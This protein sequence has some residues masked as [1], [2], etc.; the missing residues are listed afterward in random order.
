MKG[1]KKPV[2]W[3][4]GAKGE[5]KGVMLK[6]RTLCNIGKATRAVGEMIRYKIGILGIWSGFGRIKS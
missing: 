3:K 4:K 6:V 1:E 5:G 2:H